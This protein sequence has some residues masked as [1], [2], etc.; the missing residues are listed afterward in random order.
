[1]RAGG[2]VVCMES[3]VC[4]ILVCGCMGVQEADTQGITERARKRERRPHVNTNKPMHIFTSRR[5]AWPAL[6]HSRG[7]AQLVG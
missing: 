1:M 6:E 7:C 2:A 4:M 3:L 5:P